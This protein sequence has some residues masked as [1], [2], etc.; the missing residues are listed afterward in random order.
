MRGGDQ[1]KPVCSL[2]L[3]SVRLHLDSLGSLIKTLHFLLFLHLFI[4]LSSFF[5][6]G[7]LMSLRLSGI[8]LLVVG[9][10]YFPPVEVAPFPRCFSPPL[11]V[12]GNVHEAALLFY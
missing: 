11:T 8:S 5:G 7:V 1:L 12:E 9:R 10:F 3:L 4:Q 6:G 2:V